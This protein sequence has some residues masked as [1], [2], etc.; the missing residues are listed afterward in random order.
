MDV[1]Q[2]NIDVVMSRPHLDDL[3][4]YQLPPGYSLR[5][6]RPGDERLWV[7]LQAAS[8]HYN[9]ITAKLFV[10]EFGDDVAGLASRQFFLVSNKQGPI[11][12]ASAWYGRGDDPS[13]G[14][15]HWV[16]ILPEFQGRGLAKPLLSS[17]CTRLR[18][19]GYADAYL[20]TSTVRVPAINLYLHF[21]FAPEPT[22]AS[23]ADA[24]RRLAPYLK[25]STRA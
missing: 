15:V 16:A 1:R 17:V 5:F 7:S 25:G 8:D 9:D 12:T 20:T 21:G 23:E 10:R 3:P 13:P 4:S 11:G 2:E 22:S 24:W 19:L 6:Y 14:R 18:E